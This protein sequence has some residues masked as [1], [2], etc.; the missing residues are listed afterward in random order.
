MYEKYNYNGE[1][2]TKTEIARKVGVSDV[3]LSNKL[4]QTGNIDEAIRL[5]L[6]GK[7]KFYGEMVE[8]NGEM[9]TIPA[10]ARLN[11]ITSVTL[12]KYYEEKGNIY[13]ALKIAKEASAKHKMKII[14][15]GK[16]TTITALA[17]M[18]NVNPDS[19]RNA[20]NQ[21]DSLDAAIDLCLKRKEKILIE[22]KGREQTFTEIARCEDVAINTLKRYYALYGDIYKAVAISKFVKRKDKKIIIDGVESD[23]ETLSKSLNCSFNELI[24]I[25]EG[26]KLDNKK[27]QQFIMIDENK[28]LRKYCLEKSYNY[29]VIMYLITNHGKSVKE[30]ISE[31]LQNGQKLPMHYVYE[32]FGI[33]FRHLMLRYN[34]DCYKVIKIM[35][36]DDCLLEEALKKY[37]FISDNSSDFRNHNL[38][39]WLMEVYEEINYN[40]NESI[41]DIKNKFYLTK[42]ELDFIEEKTK[43]I[44]FIKRQ[45]LLFEFSQVIDLWPKE[46]VLEMLNLYGISQDELKTIIL[47]LYYPFTD[48]VIDVTKDDSKKVILESLI[49]NDNMSLDQ[50]DEKTRLFISK[51]R[52]IVKKYLIGEE[53]NEVEERKI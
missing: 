10:V 13:E 15:R 18:K 36:N 51:K 19:L 41:E 9:L 16:Q 42:E 43:R 2:L 4:K 3:T 31:Y 23:A 52:E 49:M 29:S 40:K 53:K 28:T 22:F 33:L 8:Y 14:Y 12:K 39:E 21:T 17:K 46:E 11:S 6:A 38:I 32:K 47:D 44:E 50:L 24:D 25:S 48:G 20:I 37:I 5:A 34:I 35:K 45:L 27:E 30:A 7:Q 26:K 1:M